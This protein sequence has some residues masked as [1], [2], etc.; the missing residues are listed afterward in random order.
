MQGSSMSSRCAGAVL[1]VLF[2]LPLAPGWA[3][4]TAEQMRVRANAALVEQGRGPSKQPRPSSS[5]LSASLDKGDFAAVESSIQ[6]FQKRWKNDPS[7]EHEFHMRFM[8]LDGKDANLLYQLNQWVFQR[9]TA[10]AFAARGWYLANRGA[11]LRGSL[12]NA[13]T[14]KLNMEMM[15]KVHQRARTDFE[16]AIELDPSLTPAYTGLLEVAKFTPSL[17]IDKPAVLTKIISIQ[18]MCL[19]PRR[20]YAQSLSPR[21]GGTFEAMKAY[22][23]T[24][25]TAAEAN[26]LIWS[27]KG[28]AYFENAKLRPKGETKPILNDI[29]EALKY[30]ESSQYYEYRALTYIYK[31]DFQAAATELENCIRSEAS[32]KSPDLATNCKQTLAFISKV[33]QEE[34]NRPATNLN[35]EQK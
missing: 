18:P 5:E 16:K 10:I 32:N 21:W 17:Q 12:S 20:A 11:H 31:R 1:A 9:K 34:Q 6:V 25:D 29:A 28:Q 4:S 15:F 3:A 35:K 13:N 27:L 19:E 24:L 30:S 2:L 33:M 26:P 7:M 23:D 8:L 22:T 14:P